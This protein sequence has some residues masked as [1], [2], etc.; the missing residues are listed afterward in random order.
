MRLFAA[1]VPP[2]ECLPKIA[3][4]AKPLEGVLGARMLPAGNWH[5][6]LKFIGEV[7]S[8]EAERVEKALS[9]V[10]FPPF[11]VALS[12]AGAF[13][14]EKVPRAIWV[15]GKSDGAKNLASEIEDALSFLGLAHEP[16]S[17]HLTVA[18]S[19]GV[20]DIGEFLG[21]TGDVCSFEAKSFCLMKS[22]LTP[23]GAAY[24]VLREYFAEGNSTV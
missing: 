17:V 20:A 5:L 10:R 22:T 19:K 12:G 21:K 3:E 7:G 13:P 23:A 15:G 8:K 18:R 14:S 16:F 11:P 9:A 6:T 2:K 1:I 4:A 24:E